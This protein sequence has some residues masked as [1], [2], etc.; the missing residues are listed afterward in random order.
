MGQPARARPPDCCELC[1]RDKP[2]TFH[3]LI[4]RKVHGRRRFLRRYSK[5]EM[6]ARGLH[7]CRPC[8][9]G[10]HDL[11]DET[12]LGE[13]YNTKEDLLKHEGVAR[14]VAWVARQK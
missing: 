10:I 8:H 12:E 7:L 5:H 2:L 1:G 11:I 3:H 4:P 14:H 9:S 13:R 6:K